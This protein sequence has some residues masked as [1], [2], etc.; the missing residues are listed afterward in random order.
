MY[1]KPA[2]ATCSWPLRLS[3]QHYSKKPLIEAGG[4]AAIKD[5][6]LEGEKKG[7]RGS[8]PLQLFVRYYWSKTVYCGRVQFLLD[9]ITRRSP[10]RKCVRPILVASS[11]R[12]SII[13][14]PF[15]C[16]IHALLI[17]WRLARSLGTSGSGTSLQ[18]SSSRSTLKM[19]R[20][21]SLAYWS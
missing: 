1:L 3:L 19:S 7:G 6:D 15:E 5:P 17:N 8:S 10:T 12:L 21:R 16:L 11:G 9:H 18:G 2:S 13:I 4:K 20:L 14:M